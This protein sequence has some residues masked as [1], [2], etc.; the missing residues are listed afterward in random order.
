MFLADNVGILT[1]GSGVGVAC[2]VISAVLT[3]GIDAV[4]GDLAG[5]SPLVDD[6]EYCTQVHFLFIF[7]VGSV[8]LRPSGDP[9]L[10]AQLIFDHPPPLPL[11]SSI[12]WVGAR[13]PAAD[14]CRAARD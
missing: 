10:V 6:V 11:P 12:R 4:A 3:R 5:N 2:F 9:L 14:R 7:V 1:K 8:M 13:Q